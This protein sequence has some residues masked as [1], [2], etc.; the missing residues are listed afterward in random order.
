[1]G[2][3]DV[4]SPLLEMGA[5]RGGTNFAVTSTQYG[6]QRGWR[7][8]LAKVSVAAGLGVST[9]IFLE[10]RGIKDEILWRSLS[11][12]PDDMFVPGS[13]P[14]EV[15]RASLDAVGANGGHYEDDAKVAQGVADAFD[16][17]MSG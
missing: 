8:G 7:R 14:L 12:N 11:N 15:D 13:I 6:N 4:G 9:E 5:S 1:M 3:A 2:H 10:K 17:L 16:A